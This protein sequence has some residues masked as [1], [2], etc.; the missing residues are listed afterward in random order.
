M[1]RTNFQI[2]KYSLCY[3]LRAFA[4]HYPTLSCWDVTGN[5]QIMYFMLHSTFFLLPLFF[6]VCFLFLDVLEAFEVYIENFC[7]AFTWILPVMWK[8]A[9][10]A[11]V[12][13]KG[14][15]AHEFLICKV[16]IGHI[17]VLT[18]MPHVARIHNV[19]VCV[20]CNMIVFILEPDENYVEM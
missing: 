8:A 17:G 19:C 15:Q 13:Y 20:Y 12:V 16:K 10:T 3:V 2:V 9:W 4:S 14:T 11:A 5:L 7:N 18:S 6:M 1:C